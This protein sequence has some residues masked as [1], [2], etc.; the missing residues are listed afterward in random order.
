[1]RFEYFRVDFKET[2]PAQPELNR[3][4]WEGWELCGIYGSFYFFKRLVQS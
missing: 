2:V 4:G 3:M 1:V